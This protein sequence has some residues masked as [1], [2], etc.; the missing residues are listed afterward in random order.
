MLTGNLLSIGIGGIITVG[1][2]LI[3]PAD[4]D[5]DITRRI[6]NPHYGSHSHSTVETSPESPSMETPALEKDN[7]KYQGK[8]STSVVPNLDSGSGTPPLELE[9]QDSDEAERVGLQK[10]FRFAAWSAI[11]LTFV[12]LILIPLPLFFSSHGMSSS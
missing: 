10:A 8:E 7:T 2:S 11:G 4:F 12:L 9:G 6:N 3:S 1:W 5:W